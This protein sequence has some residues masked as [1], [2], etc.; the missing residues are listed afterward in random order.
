MNSTNFLSIL[1]SNYKTISVVDY[2]IF[3]IE[4]NIS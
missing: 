1:K 2:I 4:L 3:F